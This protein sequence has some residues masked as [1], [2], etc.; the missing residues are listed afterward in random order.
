V[1]GRPYSR[2]FRPQF[3]PSCTENRVKV[4][5]AK[6]RKM[7]K[8]REKNWSALAD[9]FRTLVQTSSISISSFA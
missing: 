9:D 5:R 2:T 1:E 4:K 8:R 7:L 3:V 6:L